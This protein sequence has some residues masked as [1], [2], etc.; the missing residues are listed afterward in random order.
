M[1]R[2]KDALQGERTFRTYEAWKRACKEI[3]PNVKFDGDKDICQAGKIGEWDGAEGVIYKTKDTADSNSFKEGDIVKIVNNESFN[4]RK[5]EF[6]K[7]YSNPKKGIIAIVDVGGV[8]REFPFD[9]LSKDTK[10]SYNYNGNDY[11]KEDLWKLLVKE[12][13]TKRFKELTEAQQNGRTDQYALFQGNG[14]IY[15][16]V[17]D[18]NDGEYRSFEIVKEGNRYR[19]ISKNGTK[20]PKEF[21]T[22]QQA[23]DFIDNRVNQKDTKDIKI[24]ETPDSEFDAKELALGIKTEMEHTDNLEEATS[25]AKDHLLEPGMSHYYT[26]LLK[27]EKEL[28]EN[29]NK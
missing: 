29:E 25:I 1:I 3:E 27:M 26:N 14:G 6:I 18:T 24:N 21:L 9:N 12:G 11:E 10:D 17:R 28:K 8:K 15:A 7:E 22:E 13:K 16:V 23:E 20:H 4:G 5:G 2:T 19:I